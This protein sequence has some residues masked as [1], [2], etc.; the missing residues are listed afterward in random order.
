MGDEDY[1]ASDAAPDRESIEAFLAGYISTQAELRDI[2]AFLI[3]RREAMRDSELATL[4]IEAEVLIAQLSA[5]KNRMLIAELACF[6]DIL[7][8]Q[9]KLIEDNGKPRDRGED[10]Q[11][12]GH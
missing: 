2:I 5:N 10:T 11:A 7:A 1:I 9:Q 12:R 6:K 3:D 4:R 8:L